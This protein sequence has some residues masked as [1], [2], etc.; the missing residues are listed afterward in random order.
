MFRRSAWIVVILLGGCRVCS[1]VC[2]KSQGRVVSQVAAAPDGTLTIKSCDLTT[3]NKG[4]A[5]DDCQ[6]R[7]L[8]AP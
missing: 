4:A 7:T 8:E 6:D 1:G 2:K 5:L 3:T